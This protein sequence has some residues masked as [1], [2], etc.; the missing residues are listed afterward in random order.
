[1]VTKTK[2]TKTKKTKEPKKS[3]KYIEAIGRRKESVARVR[4][5]N[6]KPGFVINNK[7]LEQYFQL[8]NLQQKVLSPFKVLNISPDFFVS[9]KVIGGGL[10]GQAEAI[11]L[12]LSRALLK[13]NSDFKNTLRKSGFLTR[14]ARAVERKKYGLK[15]A[16]R[17]PQWKKR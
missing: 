11:R 13:S 12:G 10:N 9:A 7:T 16:R 2:Q 5:F 4:L 6:D 17:A 14:D 8:F 15:K 3:A 1:M